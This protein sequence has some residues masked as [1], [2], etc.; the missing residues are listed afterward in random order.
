M[1]SAHTTMHCNPSQK[2]GNTPKVITDTSQ[3]AIHVKSLAPTAYVGESISSSITTVYL[4][5][6]LPGHPPIN[7]ALL[8]WNRSLIHCRQS[9]QFV[10][11]LPRFLVH[12][13]FS[14][15]LLIL[16][17]VLLLTSHWIKV[18]I[19]FG[20]EPIQSGRKTLQSHFRPFRW[21]YCHSSGRMVSISLE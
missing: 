14:Q 12:Q 5:T 3:R 15:D 6:S 2:F 9:L 11:S 7:F 20:M 21:Q 17:V 4:L 10:Q 19:G 8:L 18:T 1:P 16:I 13:S